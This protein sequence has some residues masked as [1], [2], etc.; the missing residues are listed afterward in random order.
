MDQYNKAKFEA[1]FQLTTA[2]ANQVIRIDFQEMKRWINNIM[3][4]KTVEDSP[5]YDEKT[6]GNLQN[7]LD[8]MDQFQTMKD[9]LFEK[10]IPIRNVE[11]YKQANAQ[12]N[13]VNQSSEKISIKMGDEFKE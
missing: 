13:L 3:S 11:H 9:T 2:V 12:N 10:G 4:P 6:A 7:L 8:V 5:D 1:A